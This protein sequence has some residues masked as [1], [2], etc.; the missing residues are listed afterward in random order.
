MSEEVELAAKTTGAVVGALVEDSRA[1][2]PVREYAEAITSGIH[3]R[4]YPRVVRQAMA[5]AEKIER[6]GLPRRAYSVVPD[7][8]LRAI[9]EDGAMEGDE[10][11]QDRWENLLANAL[12]SVSAEVRNAFPKI[13]SEL[14]PEDAAILDS[15]FDRSTTEPIGALQLRD[16]TDFTGLDNLKRLGLVEYD[17]VMRLSGTS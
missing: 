15:A 2:G 7:R 14:E 17:Y 1:L 9:L 8:L 11:M 13:L 12:T 16:T 5:A 10:S 6:S 3:Y 4:Y